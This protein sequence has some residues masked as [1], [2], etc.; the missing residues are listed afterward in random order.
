[1]RRF[2]P[3][4]VLLLSALAWAGGREAIFQRFD[5]AQHKK[6]LEQAELSC[7]ACHQ[8]AKADATMTKADLA[9]IWSV[10]RAACHECHAP[11]QG[12][13]GAGDGINR[14]PHT[15][16]TCHES[17]KP[18]D[19]HVAGWLRH[20]GPD[21]VAAGASCSTCHARAT[22]VNCHDRRDNTDTKVHD[23]SWLSVHGIVA[24]AGPAGCDNCH[25]QAECTG[26]HA[27][28]AGFQRK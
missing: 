25:V 15:C 18:P 13:L 3:L 14:A 7:V 8:F 22:C 10:P 12:G 9:N 6:I 5:H 19:S 23:A 24:R 4:F 27:S 17:V 21:A 2:L 16:A 28:P 20:H 11:G 26:C 1:V